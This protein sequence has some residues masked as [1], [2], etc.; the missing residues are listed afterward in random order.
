[1]LCLVEYANNKVPKYAYWGIFCLLILL[2]TGYLAFFNLLIIYITYLLVVREYKTI[3]KMALI[4]VLPL[5]ILFSTL[6]KYQLF[7]NS[8]RLYWLNSQ[9]QSLSHISTKILGYNHANFLGDI[10][11]I[12]IITGIASLIWFTK[13]WKPIQRASLIASITLLSV[14][15]YLGT[16]SSER[17]VIY[18]LLPILFLAFWGYRKSRYTVFITV[19]MFSLNF[20]SF[21]YN[22]VSYH[23]GIKQ[24]VSNFREFSSEAFIKPTTWIASNTSNYFFTKQYLDNDNIH[25]MIVNP[26]ES[27]KVSKEDKVS[28]W[29][30]NLDKVYIPT[31]IQEVEYKLSQSETSR[32][33]SLEPYTAE[34]KAYYAVLEKKCEKFYIEEYKQRIVYIFDMC[35]F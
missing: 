20:L 10:Y 14:G 3:V 28:E 9:D 12:I 4:L 35:S 33:I 2:F 25:L 8:D 6:A 15:K 7:F 29:I 23:A 18:S 11:L 16:F 26:D 13:S 31:N 19:I 22:T 34:T 24:A 32:F 21:S 1:F 17:F 27:Y 5:I 30:L